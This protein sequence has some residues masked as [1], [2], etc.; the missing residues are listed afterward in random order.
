[1]YA[2]KVLSR[3]ITAEISKGITQTQGMIVKSNR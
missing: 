2:C 3:H 1:M